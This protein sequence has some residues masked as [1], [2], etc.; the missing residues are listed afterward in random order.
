MKR[1]DVLGAAF[2]ILFGASVV[3]LVLDH[4]EDAQVLALWAVS[5]LLLLGGRK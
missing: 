2:L 3:L 5:A 1:A 4:D